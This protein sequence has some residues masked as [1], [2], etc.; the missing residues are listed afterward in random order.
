MKYSAKKLN[1]LF[2]GCDCVGKKTLI[3]EL[4]KHLV[5]ADSKPFVVSHVG[6]PT[7]KEEFKE[8][9][10]Q[11]VKIVNENYGIMYDRFLLGECVYGKL[12]RG[13]Y[14]EY[15]RELELTIAPH[16]VLIL[17]TA[18]EDEVIKRFDGQFIQRSDIPRVLNDFGH[19]FDTS[20]YQVKFVVNT[21]AMSTEQC[22]QQIIAFL[23]ERGF[24]GEV[25]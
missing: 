11:F 15:M 3:R 23:G 6:A 13:Y 12:M 4:Q 22:T 18:G 9:A 24:L 14:P 1:L 25:R 21:T 16:N 20:N 2:E 19:E 10:H 17:V 8:R 7:T 5:R